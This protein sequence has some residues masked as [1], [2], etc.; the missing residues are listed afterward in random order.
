MGFTGLLY[1]GLLALGV[2]SFDAW[3]HGGEINLE[4]NVPKGYGAS[5]TSMS[6]TV[7]ENIFLSEIADID[8]VPTFVEKPRVR[9]TNDPTVV[10]MVGDML[11]L[12]KLT[13]LVQRATGIEPLVIN[14][15]ITKSKDRYQLVLVSNVE[16]AVSQ[17]LNL[18]VETAPGESVAQMIQRAAQVAML[19]YEDHLVCLHLLNQGDRGRLKL[20]E[21]SLERPGWEGLDLLIQSRIKPQGGSLITSE[22]AD[23][24]ARRQAMFTNLRGMI[25]LEQGDDKKA[26]QFF[27]DA[28]KARDDFA[29]A[30][31]NLAF[32]QVHQ[33]HYQEATETIGRLIDSGQLSNDPALLGPAYTTLGVAAWGLKRYDEATAHF[34]SANL[35]NPRATMANFYWG[36]ML[37]ERGDKAGGAV[38]HAIA[39]EN[40]KFFSPYA[41]TAIFYFQLVPHDQSPLAHL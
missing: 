5:E 1:T 12:K 28:I 41:E 22:S 36:N 23:V 19:R 34:Q 7:A 31:L 17:R 4:I 25:A 21:P 2:F 40:A 39:K 38:K 33:D 37:I 8:T 27:A 10:S 24:L 26:A 9:S 3:H 11:G 16:A 20:Y 14:G 35:A 15:S 30:R 32:V 13:L 29:I 6:D 18:T